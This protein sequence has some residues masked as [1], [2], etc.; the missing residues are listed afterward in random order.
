MPTAC[1]CFPPLLPTQTTIV[2]YRIS[3][4]TRMRRPLLTAAVYQGLGEVPTSILKTGPRPGF[5]N[6]ILVPGC[7]ACCYCVKLQT[8]P[9]TNTHTTI[10]IFGKNFALP[11]L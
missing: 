3:I 9:Y 4:Q 1:L 2:L 7:T 5:K 6:R 10:R 8:V 11:E